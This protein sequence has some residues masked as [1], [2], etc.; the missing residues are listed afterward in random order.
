MPDMD[1]FQARAALLH[2]LPDAAR[3]RTAL[4]DD[5]LFISEDVRGEPA[6]V[7]L[8]VDMAR[9]G[10]TGVKFRPSGGL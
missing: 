5:E 2:R 3:F 1:T 9:L 8:A 4:V 7:S 6:L 10:V